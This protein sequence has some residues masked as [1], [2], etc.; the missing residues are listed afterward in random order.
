M[1]NLWDYQ[2]CYVDGNIPAV[3]VSRLRE[4]MV[5]LG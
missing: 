1:R 2:E 5:L 3:Y 4:K